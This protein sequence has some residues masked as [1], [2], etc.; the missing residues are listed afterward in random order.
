MVVLFNLCTLTDM[1]NHKNSFMGMWALRP[2]L[3]SLFSDSLRPSDRLM[4]RHFPAISTAI[5]K[6]LEAHSR[7]HHH[8]LTSSCMVTKERES[9][10]MLAN[11]NPSTATNL[12]QSLRVLTDIFTHHTV[13]QM[14]EE[15]TRSGPLIRSLRRPH[16]LRAPL[17]S[18]ACSLVHSL[19]PELMGKRVFY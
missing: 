5:V 11:I 18:F 15:W 7:K 4:A 9:S 6:A 8:F 12:N 3:F 17:R 19:A 14:I 13:N 10:P 2:S 16:C 1:G